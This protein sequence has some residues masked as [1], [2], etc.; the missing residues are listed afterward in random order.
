M[1]ASGRFGKARPNRS[2]QIFTSRSGSLLI[3]LIAALIAGLLIYLFASHYNKKTTVAP[4][5][6]A[7]VFV[8]KHYIPAGTPEAEIISGGMLKPEV[9]PSTQVITGAIADPSVITGEVASA[10]IAVGQQIT[11][12]DFSHTNVTVSSYLT[13]PYRA[14]GLAIDDVHGLTAY[15]SVGSQVDMV[16]TG[17]G[18]STELFEDVTVLADPAGYA[19]LKLTQKQVLDLTNAEEI[20]DTIWL[21]LR[22]LTGTKDQVPTNYIAKVAS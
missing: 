18:G 11:I 9:V 13:G 3:A 8:A 15:L 16:A 17:K 1:E 21:T 12:T 5:T 10:S 2:G 7:T 19:V 6:T 22:P 14:V 4:P 20:G